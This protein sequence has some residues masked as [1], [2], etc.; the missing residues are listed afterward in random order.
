MT[1]AQRTRFEKLQKEYNELH[2]RLGYVY[3][4]RTIDA[5]NNRLDKICEE[6]DKLMS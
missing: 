2:E 5:I 1:K 3:D 6:M 4:V